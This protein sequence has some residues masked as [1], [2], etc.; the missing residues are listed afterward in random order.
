MNELSRKLV[1]VA[2]V[3]R[4]IPLI[5]SWKTTTAM[6]HKSSDENGNGMIP[7]REGVL[8]VWGTLSLYK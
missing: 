8:P 4:P 3:V 5:P 6:P 1:Q 2:G 7:W